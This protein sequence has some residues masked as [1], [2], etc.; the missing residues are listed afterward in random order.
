MLPAKRQA[1]IIEHLRKE[2]F[3]SLPDLADLVGVSTSTV[4]RDVDLLCEQG[5]LY[6]T[7]GGAALREKEGTMVEPAP[8]ISSEIAREAKQKI[9]RWAAEMIE[10]GQTVILDSGST[11]MEVARAALVRGIAFTAFTNDVAIA[12][13][14]ARSAAVDVHVPGGQV[15]SRSATLLGGVCLEALVRLRVDLAFVGAH[16]VSVEGASETSTEHGEIKRA[17]LEAADRTVLVA[18][19]GKFPGRSLCLFARLEDFDAILTDDGLPSDLAAELDG[20]GI[21][22]DV[23]T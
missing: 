3:G 5:H 2:R 22:L 18:D 6:R 17:I 7:H 13:V 9:G 4:R 16:A 20:R 12:A 14:L 11:T 21:K 10:K 19:S 1:K 8:E 23:L 15:R